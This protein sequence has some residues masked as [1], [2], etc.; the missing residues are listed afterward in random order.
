MR[1]YGLIVFL[2]VSLFACKKEKTV[3]DI[4]PSERIKFEAE[5]AEKKGS[6]DIEAL[7]SGYS[8]K[9]YVV[10]FSDYSAELNF[11]VINDLAGN[12][13]IYLGYSTLT[14]G[15][16]S[17]YVKINNNAI[18]PVNLKATGNTFAEVKCSRADLLQ[19]KNTLTITSGNRNFAIDY[20]RIEPYTKPAITANL[21]TPN[22]SLQA[23]KLYD[24]LRQNFGTKV[25]SG[26]MAAHSTNITEATWVHTQTGKWPALTAFD[27]I[28]HTN[29]NQG[30]VQYSAPLTLGQDW[31]M[32]NGIVGLM[33]H[34]RDPLTKSG[35]FYTAETSF[36]ISKVSDPNSNEYKAMI[37]DIDVIA[38]YLK[39]FKDAGIPV[40]W[41][42]LHEA[43]GGWFWWGAKGPEACKTLWKLMFN[44]LVT[45]HGLN[46]LI[47]VWT[48]NTSDTALN[49]YPGDEYVDIIGMDIYPGANQHGSQ[50]VE[51]KKVREIF[52]DTKIIALSECG[53]VPDPALM[54]INGDMWSWF[55]PWNGDFTESD[56]HNGVTW[57]KK[58]FSYDYVITRDQMPDLKK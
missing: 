26:T 23:V 45:V 7:I 21:V 42:P 8:G 2:I 41:R 6:L 15:A 18:T 25:I 43:A 48:S 35:A 24:F 5:Y 37:V 58:F 54:K 22:P 51:F 16:T 11:S 31:W 27:F 32:N 44:R 52:S 17:C 14:F 28:D 20:I 30:W 36:D 57:W 4:P 50:S 39:Q 13:N 29:S 40:I 19:N 9:G 33:W 55:M 46:N 49:W 47:W 56:T 3:T 34:W 10:P 53:S 1:K 38:G 12:Y